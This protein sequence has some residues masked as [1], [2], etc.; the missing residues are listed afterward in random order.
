[1]IATVAET[2]MEP[3]IGPVSVLLL[4]VLQGLAE[5]LP[6]SSSG[7]LVLARAALG[8]K[9]AGLALDV[10]LHVGT[11]GAVVFAYRKDVAQLV[12]DL[13]RARWHMW[14]WLVVGSL[15]AAVVGF[16]SREFFRG[17]AD[18]P[19]WAAMGLLGTALVLIM[20]EWGR[21]CRGS[22]EPSA[23]MGEDAGYGAP[24]LSDALVLGVAQAAALFPG[25][26]RSGSTIAAGLVRGLPTVQAA[27]LSFLLS[28][29]AVT[30][31]ALLEVP[32]ALDAGA[33]GLSV[34]LLLAGVFVAGLVGW[35]ALR[36]LVLTLSKG[37]F[38]WFALY[39]AVL[40]TSAL[41]FV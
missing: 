26:S 5:F 4:A 29:P 35:G 2:A 25:V 18:N 22:D 27:R 13:A 12:G 11:L 15:P 32:D 24:R 40:G 9:Q 23:P 30:G 8:V 21:R 7:H 28:I 14:I 39:C 37:A 38:V 10:S 36:G 31:A 1:M 16:S 41:L 17:A 20:G 33:G 6:I 19:R 34:P 3:A